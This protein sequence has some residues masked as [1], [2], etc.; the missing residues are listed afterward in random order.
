MIYD[1]GTVVVVPYP[2]VDHPVTRVRPAL[3]L[4]HREFNDSGQTILAMITTAAR[5]TWPGDWAIA[6]WD[7]AGLKTPSVVRLKLFTLQNFVLQRSVG[8]LS[9]LD[10]EAVRSVLRRTFT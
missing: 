9:A 10:L 5:S 8:A 6:E 7:M 4:S 1:A 2:F 3:V